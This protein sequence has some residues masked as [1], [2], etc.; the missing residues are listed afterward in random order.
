MI[1]DLAHSEDEERFIVIGISKNLHILYVCHCYRS[2][3]E[4]IRIISARKATE[5]EVQLYERGLS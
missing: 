4:R 3:E 5:L 2:P 1:S